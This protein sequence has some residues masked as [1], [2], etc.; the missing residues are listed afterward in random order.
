MR[1][2]PPT[3]GT[4]R[5]RRARSDC[6]LAVREG[7]RAAPVAVGVIRVEVAELLE[8]VYSP[9]NRGKEVATSL[10]AAAPCPSAVASRSHVCGDEMRPSPYLCSVTAASGDGIPLHPWSY[11]SPLIENRTSRDVP[12]VQSNP[13]SLR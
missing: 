9:G 11:L 7:T 6:S 12:T 2:L 10:T 5:A 8:G 4:P 1:T 3:P 13:T